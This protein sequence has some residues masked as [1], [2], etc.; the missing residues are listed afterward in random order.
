MLGENPNSAR[1]GFSSASVCSCPADC[2][3]AYTCRCRMSLPRGFPCVA[4]LFSNRSRCLRLWLRTTAPVNTTCLWYS[5]CTAPVYHSTIAGPGPKPG[6]RGPPG[7]YHHALSFVL[8]QLHLSTAAAVPTYEP[9]VAAT[10]TR[11]AAG[12]P[13]T[14][15]P[16]LVG[17]NLGSSIAPSTTGHTRK[18]AFLRAQQRATLKDQ[19]QYRG[20]TFTADQLQCAMLESRRGRPPPQPNRTSSRLPFMVWNCGGLTAVRFKEIRHWISLNPPTV[21]VLLE[22]FWKDD[23]EWFEPGRAGGMSFIHTGSRATRSAGI[24][25]IIP[26][27]LCHA[28]AHS[29]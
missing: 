26:G 25:V 23:A 22:T 11:R 5:T 7:K 17:V 20:R 1:G 29:A 16:L 14:Q 19:T 15:A 8:A 12:T 9:K 24:L 4:A 13:T 10:G 21:I 6:R 3:R 18:R 2:H 28:P 27:H